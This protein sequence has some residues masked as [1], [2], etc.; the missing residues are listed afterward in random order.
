[1]KDGWGGIARDRGRLLVADHEERDGDATAVPVAVLRADFETVYRTSYRA[2]LGLARTVLAD[3]AGA[4]EVVQDAFARAYARWDR[5]ESE[6]PLPYVRSVVLNLCRSRF[7]RKEPP[8]RAL[9]D[10]PS[11]EHDASI[12]A[13]RRRIQVA[14]ATLPTRQREVVALRYFGGLSTEETATAL[15]I[16]AGTVKVHLHRAVRALAAELEELRHD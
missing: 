7:R 14:L 9:P 13:R 12:E 4:E 6:D 10:A 2:M 16:A 8:L 3:D 5:I 1:V 11:A 15:D